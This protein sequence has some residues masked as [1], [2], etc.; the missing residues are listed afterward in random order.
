MKPIAA[1]LVAGGL[2]ATLLAG[3]P[4]AI[5]ATPAASSDASRDQRNEEHIK[6]L[7]AKLK[8]T[9][10]E[11][12][13]WLAVAGTM[14]DSATQIDL[15]M[16]RRQSAGGAA[17]AIDDLNAYADIAQAHADSVKKLSAAFA[18]L[19][20]AMP[21]EQKKLADSVFTQHGHDTA[22]ARISS[23]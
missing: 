5:A 11:E 2:A 16:D 3:I 22:K 21:E 8:I 15:I 20:N 10:G 7:H 1:L 4:A 17:T 18:P 14:R 9:S 6:S 12:T 23:K 13:L 19:Y